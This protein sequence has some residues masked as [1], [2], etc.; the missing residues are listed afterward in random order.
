M[1]SLVLIL[2]L[3]AITSPQG[4][5]Q[6]PPAAPPN[7]GQQTTAV[8]TAQPQPGDTGAAPYHKL[9]LSGTNAQGGT[10]I[11][12]MAGQGRDVGAWCREKCTFDQLD[13]GR[14]GG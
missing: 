10:R 8:P 13:A 9:R 3:G 12:R 5:A 6:A 7:P 14:A 4:G 1:R 11:E 2:A